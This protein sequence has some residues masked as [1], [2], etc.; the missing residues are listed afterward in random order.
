MEWGVGV[1]GEEDLQHGAG[2]DAEDGDQADGYLREPA[3]GGGKRRQEGSGEG[4]EGKGRARARGGWPG[5]ARGGGAAPGPARAHVAVG[6]G[7]RWRRDALGCK[8]G[9]RAEEATGAGGTELCGWIGDMWMDRR[10][11]DGSEVCKWIGD[12][13]MNRTKLHRTRS[14][15]LR[16]RK[17]GAR[18]RPRH[19]DAAQS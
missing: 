6:V 12:M 5:R 1:G 18:L 14:A 9:L 7:G 13:R 17:T 3:L 8:Q 15:R 16:A 11:A 10:F 19:G 2:Y 4:R